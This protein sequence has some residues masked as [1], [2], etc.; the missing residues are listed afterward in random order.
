M[1]LRFFGTKRGNRASQNRACRIYR[2]FPGSKGLL[3]VL[4]GSFGRNRQFFPCGERGIAFALC[5]GGVNLGQ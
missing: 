5:H 1:A 4:R 2:G 3:P